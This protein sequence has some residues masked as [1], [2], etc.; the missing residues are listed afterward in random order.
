MN[1]C[2]AVCILV[3]QNPEYYLKN[4]SNKTSLKK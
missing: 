4:L 2:V 3:M 1:Y